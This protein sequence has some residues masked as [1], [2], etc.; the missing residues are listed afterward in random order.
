[1]IV[2]LLNRLRTEPRTRIVAFG[3]SNTERRIHGLHWF[4]WLDLA[5]KQTFG[6]VH[7]CINAGL[8]GDTTRGLLKRFD[9]DVALYQPHAVL[10]TIGGNDSNP[11]S[12]ID[13]REFV[14]NLLRLEGRIRALGAVAIFQ[15]YYS[16]DVD[17]MATEHGSAFLRF[18][19]LVRETAETTG[20]YLVDHHR[21]WERLRGNDV[22]Q[23]RQLMLDP[24]HV[25]PLGNM[26]LGFDL[27]R[28]FQ[29]RL[30]EAQLVCCAEGVR[31]QQ[32]LDALEAASDPAT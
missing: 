26:V 4:D 12:G 15:T 6:R 24:L 30:Q 11:A 3:S 14:T 21:R 27:S 28:H 22:E 19:D 25:N 23:Y 1:M 17:A 10:V 2:S 29:A 13:D 9:D 16:A 32:V 31:I 7:H 18:M 20:S 5:I 8:G